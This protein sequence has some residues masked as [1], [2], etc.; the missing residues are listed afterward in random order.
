MN[1]Q[2]L[3]HIQDKCLSDFMQKKRLYLHWQTGCG[4]SYFMGKVCYHFLKQDK[5]IVFVC[6][7]GVFKSIRESFNANDIKSDDYVILDKPVNRQEFLYSKIY[8]QKSIIV[9]SFQ[10]FSL[11]P[12][13]GKISSF[14]CDLFVFDE[15]HHLNGE[16]TNIS[17]MVKRFFDLK[18][19]EFCL[20]GSGTPYGNNEMELFNAMYCLDKRVFGVGYRTFQMKYFVDVNKYTNKNH[21][22][23]KI[24]KQKK[25]EFF[26]K[27]LPYF[28]Y[29]RLTD[30]THNLPTIH[31][32]LIRLDMTD[33]QLEVYRDLKNKFKVDMVFFKKR[34]DKE[35]NMGKNSSQAFMQFYSSVLSQSMALRQ[36]C[37]GFVYE[38]IDVKKFSP[39]ELKEKMKN[40]GV[41][42]FTTPKL[43]RLVEG[44]K[45]SI[46]YG[47]CLIWTVFKETYK[48]IELALK[49]EGIGL[50]SIT[51]DVS[52]SKRQE[53]ISMFKEHPF[54]KVFLAHP[55]CG[56][57][58]LNL[59]EARYS[60]TY[61]KDYSYIKEKQKEGRNY[62]VNSI[63]W[64][65]ALMSVDM[66]MRG[67]IEEVISSRVKNK[68]DACRL[69]YKY[70]NN[71]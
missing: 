1:Y 51:G 63:E 26:K 38:Y 55:T 5:R 20:F 11:S 2:K 23:F 61:S 7:A 25:S 43:D 17:K 9:I 41:M 31:K 53:L 54:I 4:K 71:S 66:I 34:L 15:A 12:Y 28:S 10:T 64:N 32:K 49:A 48:D 29:L 18:S 39:V 30:I 22:K 21:K 58:G 65:N 37:N 13:F 60:I 35:L 42:K 8:D 57:T 14:P 68:A 36:V 24:Q 56:G 27:I 6:P 3:N 62:R 40:R 19:P 69:F 46:P 70:L 45:K 16:G 52:V 44:V 33:K 67:T 47:K 59:Q 50:V